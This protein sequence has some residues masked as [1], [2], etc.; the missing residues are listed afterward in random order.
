MPLKETH[1]SEGFREIDRW[2]GGVG[3]MAHPDETMQRAS[4]ALVHDGDLWIIDPVDASELDDL[5]ADFGDVAGVV[6]LLDRHM[7]DAEEIA[8]RHEV[9]L[10][11]PTWV[12]R[13][14]SGIPVRRFERTLADTDFRV[15]KLFDNPA[16]QEAGL[17]DE[18]TGTLVVP[19]SVGTAEYFRTGRE[20]LGVHPMVRL[21]P[22]NEL[23]GLTP[24]RILVGHGAGVFDDAAVTLA[25][26][27]DGS[28]RRY[29]SLLASTV[30]RL[31]PL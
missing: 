5:L 31:S 29:P 7:R 8:R 26:T 20:R 21:L 24:E 4:H 30:R 12:R 15:L 28:R 2:D 19:E 16:W 9:P 23:R 17:Y 1:T 13:S 18:T 3:W 10:Y 22:P 11:L 6:V 25:D 27:L 14:V